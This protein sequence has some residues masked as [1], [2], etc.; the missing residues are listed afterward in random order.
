MI[1][2]IAP[3]IFGF[4]ED[5]AWSF[6]WQLIVMAPGFFFKLI[7]MLLVAVIALAFIP[8]LG[9]LQSLQTLVLGG[10]ALVFVLGILDSI[11]PNI[12]G[13]KVEFIPG[14]W[15]SAGLIVVGGIMSWIGFMAVALV[16]VGLEMAEEGL[17]QLIMF[18]VGAIFGFVLVFMYGAWLGAQVRGGF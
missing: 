3:I 14:F 17:G 8:I 12:V 10:I 18:P 7:G 16:L 6:P 4:V 13:D 2:T 5:A 9:Q 15:F 11:N 1:L